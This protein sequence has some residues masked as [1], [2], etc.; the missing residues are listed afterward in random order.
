MAPWGFDPADARCPVLLIHGLSD[1]NIPSYHSDEIKEHNPT[2]VVIW[3]IPGA[4]HTQAHKAAPTEFE[5][6][7]SNWFESHGPA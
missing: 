7:V 2:D 3:K 4:L 6:R 5:N 1:R